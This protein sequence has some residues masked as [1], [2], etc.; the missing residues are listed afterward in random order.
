MGHGGE[1]RDLPAGLGWEVGTNPGRVLASWWK[2]RHQPPVGGGQLRSLA[3]E[4]GELMVASTTPGD[5]VE[6]FR[7]EVQAF[8]TELERELYAREKVGV[9]TSMLR[10]TTP[11]LTRL[12]WWVRIF[13]QA[14]IEVKP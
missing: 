4:V 7:A 9:P 2:R 1:A 14:L 12:R 11:Q 3:R 5:R 8:A 6:G 10:L 13:Q